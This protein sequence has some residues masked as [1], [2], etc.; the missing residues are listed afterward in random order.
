MLAV[1]WRREPP[2]KVPNRE[3]ALIV[4]DQNTATLED[5]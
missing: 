1:A 5:V 2:A 4:G 3:V